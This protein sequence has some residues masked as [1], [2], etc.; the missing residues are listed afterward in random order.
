MKD[1]NKPVTGY[2][3]PHEERI[4]LPPDETDV[5]LVLN[6]ELPRC[7]FCTGT[8]STFT[9]YFEHSGIYQ[10]YVHCTWCMAQIFVNSRDR[11]DARAKAIAK[12]KKRAGAPDAEVVPRATVSGLLAALR[13]V[14]KTGV[15]E[16]LDLA[17]IRAFVA[18]GDHS[19]LPAEPAKQAPVAVIRYANAGD[20]RNE[21]PHV[22]SCRDLPDGE[23]SV[24]LHPA[25]LSDT[26]RL[27]LAAQDAL[28]ANWRENNRMKAI[29][30]VKAVLCEG[31]RA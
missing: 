18:D 14:A 1:N 31:D 10:S 5:R 11:E 29:A 20:A 21:M 6:A 8:P 27:V 3:M 30:M 19:A 12:W 4:C 9:R 23:Y 28:D 24:Y 13:A 7:P 25:S 22:V 2:S 16:R 17:I 15:M 26:D